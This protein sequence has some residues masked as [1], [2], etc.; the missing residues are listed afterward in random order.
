MASFPNTLATKLVVGTEIGAGVFVQKVPYENSLTG[1]LS[2]LNGPVVCGVF[3]TFPGLGTVNIGPSV[4]TSG[5]PG[6]MG[7]TILH[8]L[9]GMTVTAPIAANFYGVVNTY[10]FKNNFGP[11]LTFGVKQ[12]LGLL[13]KIGLGVEVGGKVA[14]EPVNVEAAPVKDISAVTTNINGIL[15]LTGVGNV[16]AAINSKKGFD[17]S[18]PTKEGWRLSHI[19]VEGPTADV[20]IRGKLEGTNR[21]KLPDYWAGLVDIDSVTVNLTPIGHYQELF[22]DKIEWG[23]EVVVKNNNAGPVNCY[24]HIMAERIDT[25]KNIP[26]Y[27]GTWEDYPGDNSTRSIVGKDYDRRD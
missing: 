16:A 8:P 27:E 18:H 17:I 10:G 14:A 13:N 15:N 4:P 25:E 23:K 21:I 1:G 2:V 5:V 12:T 6:T 22:V 20:Y 7:L 9:M 3:P 11:N 26:E 24:Y 19:C